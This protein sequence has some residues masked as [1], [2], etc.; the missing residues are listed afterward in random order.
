MKLNPKL[1]ARGYKIEETNEGVALYFMLIKNLK[2]GL[3][4]LKFLT[5][6]SDKEYSKKVELKNFLL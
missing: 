4:R 1:Y 3:Y 2:N 6:M 5:Q